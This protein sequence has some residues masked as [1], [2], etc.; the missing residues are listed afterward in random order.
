MQEA[1]VCFPVSF[2]LKTTTEAPKATDMD[3]DHLDISYILNVKSKFL[4]VKMLVSPV[5]ANKRGMQ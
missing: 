1:V 3:G 5:K 2:P 4:K